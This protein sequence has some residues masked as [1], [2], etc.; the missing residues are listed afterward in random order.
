M[1]TTKIVI[2]G[3]ADVIRPDLPSKEEV[4][5]KLEAIKAELGPKLKAKID[6]IKAALGGSPEHPIEIPPGHR[7]RP[8]VFFPGSPD[9]GLP[10]MV[11]WPLPEDPGEPAQ[12]LPP[13]IEHPIHKPEG[14]RPERPGRPARPGHPIEKPPFFIPGKPD[15][16]LPPMI[17]WPLPEEECSVV[18]HPEIQ[19]LGRKG[20]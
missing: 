2:V 9:Q 10:P 5:S 14:G 12:P 19:P 15:Q 6:E 3:D 7:P 11:G 17:G 18:E 20:H 16:G 4:I 8:P 1:S 13:T